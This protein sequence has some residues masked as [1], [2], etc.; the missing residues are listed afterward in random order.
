MQNVSTWPRAL[1]V[2]LL[3]V[4]SLPLAAAG[5]APALQQLARDYLAEHPAAQ[6]ARADL[7]R[8]LAEARAVGQPLYNPEIELDYED[9]TDV[10]KTIGFSQTL[11]W[12]GKR[13][14]RDTASQD[15]VRA[16]QAALA[17]TRQQMLGEL[18]TELS[19]VVTNAEAARL[20]RRRVQLL[21]EF[22]QLAKQRYAAGD[23]GQTDVDLAQ[24]AVSEA[25]M[26]AASIRADAMASEARLATLVPTPAGGWPAL[27]PLPRAITA[28]N[29]DELLQQH[30]G[31]RQAQAEAA[32][33]RASVDIARRDRRP[34]PTIG[35]R[36]G[37]EDDDTLLGVTVSIPLF[38]RNSFRAEL[39]AANAEA[40][41]AEQAYRRDLRR[42][43]G[44]LQS[45]AQRY[46]L[47]RVALAY[48]E[49]TGKT[50]LQD[51][52]ELLKRL[53][54]SGEISTTDYLVQLQQTL[55]TRASAV[56]LQGAAWSAWIAWLTASGTT[57]HWL[58]L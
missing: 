29:A 11:D 20:A 4:P 57:E 1:L 56:E 23:V 55:D 27:P 26:Q 19:S 8:A 31:L 51:R 32:A 12:A 16:A 22:L 53:W 38:V 2:C 3:L 45:A 48:W 6:A 50:S 41:R 17:A 14:A 25:R 58:G 15:S 10:T 36:G 49:K 28:F 18:L 44:S 52:I 39:D 24:L 9:A 7:E 5:A 13:R 54:E 34:D 35:I 43:N 30:P 33:A 40:T 46:R 21:D 47:T 37:E 42:A